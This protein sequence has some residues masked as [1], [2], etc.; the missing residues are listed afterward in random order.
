MKQLAQSMQEYDIC[1]NQYT[2]N[3]QLLIIFPISL[4]RWWEMDWMS[5]NKLK[6]S[7][8]KIEM[9]LLVIRQARK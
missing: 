5:A 7:P 4:Q 2:D 6:Q 8:A 1:Y 9:F 3:T